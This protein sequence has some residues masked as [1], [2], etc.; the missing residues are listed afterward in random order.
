ML[1]KKLVSP[2]STQILNKY[3]QINGLK[4][5]YIISLHASAAT[6]PY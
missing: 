5:C 1:I 2:A 3:L 4:G 6:N